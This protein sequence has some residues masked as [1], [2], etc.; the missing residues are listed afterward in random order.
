MP[1][2]LAH[3]FLLDGVFIYLRNFFY[4]QSPCVLYIIGI[5][6]AEVVK[7]GGYAVIYLILIANLNV[8]AVRFLRI[9][10]T[11]EFLSDG[12]EHSISN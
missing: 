3:L 4:G 2:K 1:Y 11:V 6:R 7:V 8:S 12:D 9:W 5:V 10:M